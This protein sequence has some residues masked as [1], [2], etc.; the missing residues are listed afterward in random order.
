MVIVDIISIG[1]SHCKH[2]LSW[3]WMCCW[4]S[5]AQKWNITV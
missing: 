2:C 4:R 3:R 1:V 5:Q